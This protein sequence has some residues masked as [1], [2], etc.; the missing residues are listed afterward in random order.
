M[1]SKHTFLAIT[2]EEKFCLEMTHNARVHVNFSLDFTTTLQSVDNTSSETFA[3]EKKQYLEKRN[4]N[5]T[6]FLH[7]TFVCTWDNR[8]NM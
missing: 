8:N 6:P 1:H 3:V 4:D 5:T 2:S 7:S